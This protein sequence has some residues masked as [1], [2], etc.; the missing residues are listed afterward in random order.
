MSGACS[1]LSLLNL[2]ISDQKPIEDQLARIV[3][4]LRDIVNHGITM[5]EKMQ[6]LL[7]LSK[8]PESYRSM[9][10][11]LMATVELDKLNVETIISKAT[12]EE[13]MRKSGQAANKVSQTK[14]KPKGPCSHYNSPTHHELTCYQKYPEKHPKGK[15]NGKGKK[16]KGKKPDNGQNQAHNVVESVA[17][18]I[19]ASPSG[20]SNIAASFYDEAMAS[21]SV[22]WT[23]WC[24]DSGASQ[25]ITFDL[26]DFSEYQPFDVPVCFNTAST[27]EGSVIQA[28]GEGTVTAYAWLDGQKTEVSLNNVYYLPRAGTR[29]FST[30]SIERNGYSLFQGDGRMCIFDKLPDGAVK[31]GSTI[32]ITGRK[33]LE[34]RY[35]PQSNVYWTL[36]EL[37]NGQR[38]HLNVRKF[39]TW[40]RRFGHAGKNVMRQLPKHTKGVDA[41]DPP[42]EEP[43]DGC[44]YGKST[45]L[46]FP[47]SEKRATEPLELVHTDLDGPMRTQAIGG[48]SYFAGFIDNYSGLAREYYLKHKLDVIQAFLDFKAWAETQTDKKIKKI[49]S[50]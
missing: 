27:G 7:L 18:V 41:V 10:S 22:N 36:L 2:E 26:A 25:H 35:N 44:A 49:C 39:K 28:L 21:N 23:S 6:A 12:S 47:P 11:V 15:G 13:S 48:W 5:D 9:I 34:A 4:R 43:C 16:D 29:L 42:D 45:R 33:I 3:T 24:M 20:S 37:R 46:P 30:G 32:R 14:P 17:P 40:H 8:V 31:F 1:S 50:D 19:V 38:I